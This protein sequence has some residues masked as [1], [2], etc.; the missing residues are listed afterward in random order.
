MSSL[1]FEFSALCFACLFF[2]CLFPSRISN[3]SWAIKYKSKDVT[4]AIKKPRK[5]NNRRAFDGNSDVYIHI[6]LGIRILI[7]AK[8]VQKIRI[9]AYLSGSWMENLHHLLCFEM[10]RYFQHNVVKF[11][12]FFSDSFLVF[13]C[14]SFLRF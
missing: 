10:G 3:Q 7:H 8:T 9:H 4:L 6:Y 13:K 5:L 12:L 1:L 2:Y 11:L 14:L